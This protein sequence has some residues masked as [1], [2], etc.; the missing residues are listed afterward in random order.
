MRYAL[1]VIAMLVFVLESVAQ[2]ITISG[3]AVDKETREP[4]PFASIGIQGKSIGT[5]TNL[6]GEFDFH[7]PPEYRNEIVVISML[8]YVNFE[9]PVW[10]LSANTTFELSKSTTVL[11]EVVVTDS[12]SGGDILRIALSRIEKNYP[13]KPFMMEGF[14]RDVK[15]VASTHIS[16]LEAAVKIYDEDYAEPRNKYKLR[17]RVRLMEVRKSLGYESR[18]TAYFDQDNL[19]EDLLLHNN[20]RYRQI[21]AREEMYNAMSRLA[22]SYY[23]G[24]EIY[25]IAHTKDYLLKIFVDKQDYSIIHLEFETGSS[26]ELVG[27]KKKLVSRFAGL[28]KTIDFRPVDGKMYLS[29]M[30][31]TSKVTWHDIKTDELK[32][33]TELFQQLLINEVKP[34]TSE[35]IGGTEK[36]RNYGLQ[37]QDQPYNKTF[38]DNYNVI[39]DTPLDK[40]ILEDLEKAGPL[41]KQFEGYNN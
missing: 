28:R 17:E 16:L 33:E 1:I 10:T 8:G 32:F 25:V 20:I 30:S 15:K 3:V 12:L 38:W 13:M 18:F 40:K 11:N 34:N 41:Q 39:K 36:M 9:A 27:K 21:E 29:Y 31:I 4:L 35:R 24:H 14:Y 26:N 37:Y 23:N 7:I 6:Q 5:I 22:D 19:L 2:K